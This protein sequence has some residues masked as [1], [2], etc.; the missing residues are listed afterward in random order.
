[1]EI[2]SAEMLFRLMQWTEQGIYIKEDCH[3]HTMELIFRVTGFFV[4]VV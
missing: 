4:F 3:V 2:L 1:M